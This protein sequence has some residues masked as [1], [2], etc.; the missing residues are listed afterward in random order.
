MADMVARHACN[1]RFWGE[2]M[3]HPKTHWKWIGQYP[4]HLS[5]KET[6]ARWTNRY[7]SM[8]PGQLGSFIPVSWQCYLAGHIH[9]PCVTD[10]ITAR[11]NWIPRNTVQYLWREPIM[12]SM[13]V[14][15]V[16]EVG[17]VMDYM[18]AI[19][20]YRTKYAHGFGVLRSLCFQFLLDSCDPPTHMF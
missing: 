14:R 12:F 15:G 20:I 8:D 5:N 1:C 18:N 3:P 13:E 4:W 9:P 11:R 17:R 16:Y 19:T 10:H 6:V 7:W 2:E